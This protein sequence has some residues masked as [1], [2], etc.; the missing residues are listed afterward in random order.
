[1]VMLTPNVAKRL[2]ELHE[3]Q[4]GHIVVAV[5][6]SQLERKKRIVFEWKAPD[7]GSQCRLMLYPDMKSDVLFLFNE[8]K[9]SSIESMLS[10]FSL[11]ISISITPLKY[12]VNKIF[13]I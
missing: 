9:N 2:M 8:I 13:H 11:Y 3:A 1:M 7:C 5:L 4:Q 10:Y 12:N 6:P